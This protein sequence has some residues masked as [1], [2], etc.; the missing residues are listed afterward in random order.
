MIF[1]AIS[2]PLQRKK[3]NIISIATAEEQGQDLYK[4]SWD[5]KGDL[6]VHDPVIAYQAN[7][8]YIFSTGYGI[9][10]KISTDG[11]NWRDVGYVLESRDWHRQ[12]I[13]NTDNNLWAP[14]ISFYHGYYYL[15][16]SKSI[17][18]SNT[19]VI[20]LA[21]NETLDPDSSDYFWKD[22]GAVISSDPSRDYNCI[23]PNLVIDQNNQPWLAFGSFWTGIKLIKL[24]AS[25]MKPDP[26][27]QVLSIA[28]RP[29]NTAIEAPFIIYRKGY[30]YLFVSFDHCCRGI[31]SDYK[32]MVGRSR[33][34][35]G[36][37]LDKQG[38]LMMEGGGT[39]LDAGDERWKGPGHCGVYQSA[40]TAILIN[41]AYDAVNNGS[42]T[43]QIRP[44]YWD[45]NDWPFLKM[46]Q[47]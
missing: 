16:Y 15:Y 28:S 26:G 8:W 21:S 13:P 44:L 25:S 32:I 45:E 3:L 39:L 35:G 40:N 42:P 47:K 29:G 14:D 27:E 33:D 24:N 11:S 23:D 34:I 10:M 41:H 30:Y 12:F 9:R 20:G 38:I 4:I 46:Q 43:L 2:V 6:S 36:P 18:G 17:F 5:L 7:R 22:Q 31:M 1:S 37:Y 19:S